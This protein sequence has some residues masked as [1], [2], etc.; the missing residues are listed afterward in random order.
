[1]GR[2]ADKRPAPPSKRKW[3]LG[4][5]NSRRHRDENRL[6]PLFCLH[7]RPTK[8]PLD[9]QRHRNASLCTSMHGWQHLPAAPKPGLLKPVRHEKQPSQRLNAPHNGRPMRPIRATL[10][11]KTRLCANTNTLCS[12]TTSWF[13][14]KEMAN[15]EIKR[16][17]HYAV[18]TIVVTLHREKDDDE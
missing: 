17:K 18:T 8:L 1:M 14:S 13:K 11:Q 2:K 4:L 6:P 16:G 7:P 5:Y 9:Y 12:H 10:S 3:I 15:F